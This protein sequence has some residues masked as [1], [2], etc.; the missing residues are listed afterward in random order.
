MHVK[1]S[2]APV[3]DAS[4]GDLHGTSRYVFGD[5]T[6][7]PSA[8]RPTCLVNGAAVMGF[9]DVPLVAHASTAVCYMTPGS[10]SSS[11]P[12]LALNVAQSVI[13]WDEIII[14]HR[15]VQDPQNHTW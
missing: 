4:I 15:M 8:L 14:S 11:A 1:T 10:L 13:K 5:K 12:I 3:A 9:Y 2:K 6:Y 7:N